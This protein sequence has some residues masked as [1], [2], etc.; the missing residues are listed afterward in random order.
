MRN[1][2][3]PDEAI[4]SEIEIDFMEVL[5]KACDAMGALWS[6]QDNEIVIE[7]KEEFVA[8]YVECNI[9]THRWAAVFNP[10]SDKLECPNCSNMVSFTVLPT[11]EH[12][13]L[14]I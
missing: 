2:N 6:I 1:E 5:N 4:E 10:D 9:C 3:P 13:K 8:E 12:G 14:I 11:D 7:K